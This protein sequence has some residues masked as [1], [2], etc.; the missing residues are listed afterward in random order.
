M[1][2][3]AALDAAVDVLDADAAARDP[4]IGR[5]L[6]PREGS[7]P[8]LFRGPDDLDLVER[9]RQEAEILEPP[10]ARGPGRGRGLCHP[11]IVSAAPVS[12][13]QEEDHPRRID[14]PHM[15]HGMA[16]FLATITAR[17]LKR[18]LG[19]RDAPLCP[20]LP[21][22]GEGAAGV[23]AAAGVLAGGGGSAGGT[24]R[25]AAS[26]SVTP[27][28]WANACK[29]RQGASP[30]THRV[31]FSTTSMRCI[32]GLALLWPLPNSRP[33]TTWRGEVFR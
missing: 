25:V 20:I 11:L 7:A 8:G 28:R 22:R 5:F 23:G 19:A 21:T 33:C 3:A 15:F 29:E 10:A 24:T 13:A 27:I 26:A 4:P 14:Q 2:D 6:R 16:C 1:D 32:H 9:E 17:L 18:V 12:V 31:A 30:R